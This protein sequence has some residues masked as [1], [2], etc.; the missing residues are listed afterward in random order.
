MCSIITSLTN[1][2]L[3]ISTA[4]SIT[5]GRGSSSTFVPRLLDTIFASI[6]NICVALFSR[7]YNLV[8]TVLI[9]AC[10]LFKELLSAYIIVFISAVYASCDISIVA[11][12]VRSSYFISA[13]R[14]TL[15]V[16]IQVVAVRTFC[17]FCG[18]ALNAV[19][20]C[21]AARYA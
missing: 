6:T 10:R 2:Q 7:L 17:T 3:P 14:F 9:N 16:W 18:V 11:L 13:L 15:R 8:P 4:S 1:F 19:L 21:G 20:V 12:L 5:E